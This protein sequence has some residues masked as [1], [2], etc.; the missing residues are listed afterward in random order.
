MLPEE[1]VVNNL[2]RFAVEDVDQWF[3]ILAQRCSVYDYL[4]EL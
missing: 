4:I 1:S 2:V 3:C